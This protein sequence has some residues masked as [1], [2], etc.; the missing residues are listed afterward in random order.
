[1]TVGGDLIT[2]GLTP[3]EFTCSAGKGLETVTVNRN[4]S[5]SGMTNNFNY[6]ATGAAHTNSLR[7]NGNFTQSGGWVH[8][9]RL[10][11]TATIR[12]QGNLTLNSGNLSVKSQSGAAAATVDPRARS[13]GS[14][15]PLHRVRSA[16]HADRFFVARC[17][18]A[19]F[20]R[21]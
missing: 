8:F 18:D 15:D 10:S 9:S 17:L 21:R 13:V 5:V 16:H 4:F 2:G 20:G 12:I 14:L 6:G 1:M 11:G 7:V 3:A 19:R